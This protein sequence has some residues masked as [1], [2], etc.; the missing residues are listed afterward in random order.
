MERRLVSP[1][2]ATQRAAGGIIRNQKN[3][4]KANKTTQ[5]GERAQ[6]WATNLIAKMRENEIVG[7]DATTAFCR[8]YKN[9]DSAD[10]YQAFISDAERVEIFEPNTYT[11][12]IFADGSCCADWRE[13]IERFYPDLSDLIAEDNDVRGRFAVEEI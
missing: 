6:D 11:L 4:M 10:A 3:N 2:C 13:G 5:A 12:A 8:A 9:G 7:D 1:F